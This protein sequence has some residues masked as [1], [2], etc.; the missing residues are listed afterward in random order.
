VIKLFVVKSGWGEGKRGKDQKRGRAKGGGGGA[1]P[2][3]LT[4]K[5]YKRRGER[6]RA[7]YP[8]STECFE[9][10]NKGTKNG[11]KTGK[12]KACGGQGGGSVLDFSSVERRRREKSL[13]LS[14]IAS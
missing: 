3:L 11:R 9:H 10:L 4:T 1:Q 6:R 7:S 14:C 12:M 5:V 2:P 13:I 8:Q